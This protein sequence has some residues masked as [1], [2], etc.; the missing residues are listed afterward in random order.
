MFPRDSKL[1]EAAIAA[2]TE[3]S[4][5]G[6]CVW[7]LMAFGSLSASGERNSP[8]CRIGRTSLLGSGHLE[9]LVEWIQ[10]L[11]GSSHSPWMAKGKLQFPALRRQ[12]CRAGTSLAQFEGVLSLSG[13]RVSHVMTL[14][15]CVSVAGL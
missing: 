8:P 4:K 15:G 5:H 14:R 6:G 12:L 1:K 2:T 3:N 10:A 13:L 9:R 7:L 11:L